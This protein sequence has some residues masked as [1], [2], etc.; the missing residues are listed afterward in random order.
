MQVSQIHFIVTKFSIAELFFTVNG[1]FISPP[2]LPGWTW[3]PLDPRSP[4]RTFNTE[5]S[6]GQEQV[7]QDA[8]WIPEDAECQEAPNPSPLWDPATGFRVCRSHFVECSQ[9]LPPRSFEGKYRRP[10]H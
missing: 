1:L 4:L 6:W 9:L 10:L 8:S 7:E 2:S 3:S 5:L